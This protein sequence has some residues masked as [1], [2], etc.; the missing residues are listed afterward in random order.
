MA[1]SRARSNW[2]RRGGKATATLMSGL[3]VSTMFT[4]GLSGLAMAQDNA[5]EPAASGGDE[6]AASGGD[7]IVVTARRRAE[8]IMEVPL[9]IAA[10]QGEQLEAF[11][12]GNFETLDVPGVLIER[13][14]MSDTPAIRGIA[15]GA[16]L[17]FEQSAPLY[18]DGVYYGRGRMTRGAFLD[19]DGVE[20]LR[21]PQP[22][23]YGKN[24]VAGAIGLRP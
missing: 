14:G 12:V 2:F 19:L 6:P 23:Y 9:S 10:V 13:G 7:V 21:G 22:I 17:G 24:A 1:H 16:N 18:V 8:S 3:L 4:S 5:D 11:G 15:S 20:V